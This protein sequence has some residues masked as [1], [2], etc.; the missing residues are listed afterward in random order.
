M[1]NKTRQDWVDTMNHWELG[2]KIK[3]GHT[4]Y[5]NQ[6]L[7][8]RM[9]HKVLWDFEIETNHLIPARILD[10]VII[11]KKKNLPYSRLNGLCRLDIEN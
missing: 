4:S 10:L 7:P 6:Y 9:R 3:F 2:K 1:E 8:R 11:E 5:K